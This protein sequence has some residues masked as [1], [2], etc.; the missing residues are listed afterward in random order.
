MAF[1]PAP[2][3]SAASAAGAVAAPEAAP[4]A[5]NTVAL[6]VTTGAY[7]IPLTLRAYAHDVWLRLAFIQYAC[8][9]IGRA[10]TF[11]MRY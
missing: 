3:A 4:A 1:A 9:Q 11:S 6:F 2:V 5:F 7:D 8:P 10:Y